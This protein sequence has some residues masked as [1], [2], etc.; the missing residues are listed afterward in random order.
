MTRPWQLR[1]IVG[2]ARRHRGVWLAVAGAIAL[3][4]FCAAAACL[5]VRSGRRAADPGEPASHL[6]VSLKDDLATADAG[7]LRR[8]LGRLPGV[9]EVR[10]VSAREALD[11]LVRA[12]GDRAPL[13][14]GVGSDLL[15]PTL[16]VAV[17]PDAAE[18]LAFRL[19]RVRGV[20]DVDLVPAAPPGPGSDRR[21]VLGARAAAAAGGGAA[22]L[23]LVAALAWL[24]ARLRPELAVLLTLGATRATSLRPAL[25]LVVA[26]SVLGAA[27]GLLGATG[28]AHAWLG[29]GGLA[30]REGVLGGAA[31]VALALVAARL[32]LGGV[33]AAG[34]G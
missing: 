17:R 3:A 25:L 19:R 29:I 34:A 9:E 6:I 4:G 16:E 2:D 13:L 8:V 33:E 18:G 5:A 27:V 23:A 21:A 11:Q 22:L 10:T 24:R 14:D 7:D 31:L 1:R 20:V 26:A 28:A 12:L 30:A 15:F 32:A